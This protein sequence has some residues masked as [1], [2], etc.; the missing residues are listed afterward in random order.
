MRK[1]TEKAVKCFLSMRNF[2]WVNTKVYHTPGL[3]EMT[4]FWNTIARYYIHDAIVEL[5]DWGYQGVTTKERLNWILKALWF[6]YIYQKKFNW[7]YKNE[8][9]EVRLFGDW[10]ARNI[11][12]SNKNNND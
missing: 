5:Y 9:W 1:I 6:G 12:V 3:V 8:K 4:L 2:N 10:I 7:Y 11:L